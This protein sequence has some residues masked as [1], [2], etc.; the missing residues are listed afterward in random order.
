MESTHRAPGVDKPALVS[1]TKYIPHPGI[2]HAG[3]QY[4]LH[5]YSALADTFDVLALAP[6]SALNRAALDRA[7]GFD[8]EIITGRGAISSGRSKPLADLESL[9]AGSAAPR[10]VR[11]AIARGSDQMNKIRDAD[12]V[13]FQWSEMMSLAPRVRADNPGLPLVGVA[14][15]VITQRWVRAAD[16]ARPGLSRAYR[17]AAVRS[18]SRERESFEALDVVIAFSEKDAHLVND[19]SPGTRVEVVRPGL[20]PLALPLR[21][22]PSTNNPTV[23]FTGALNRSD[24]SDAVMWFLENVWDDVHDRVPA[25]RFVVAGAGASKALR[26]AVARRPHAEMTGYVKSLEPYYASASVFVVPLFTGAGVKFKTIDAMLRGVPVVATPVGVEGIDRASEF[27][28]V[29]TAPADFVDATVEALSGARDGQAEQGARWAAEAYGY[30]SF[31]Q[32][33]H[34]IYAELADRRVN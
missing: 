5:H 23:L 28:R 18:R 4:A 19:I 16:A 30:A 26:R 13:E 11:L 17:W 9:V 21:K 8:A 10:D 27:A 7:D 32:R 34:G 15:D 22:P 1:F 25:A 20:S 6:D 29:A 33:L 2:A 24:N 3:G 12:V 31:R 14:H